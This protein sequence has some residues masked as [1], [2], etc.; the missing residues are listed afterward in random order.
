MSVLL[1]APGPELV[2]RFRVGQ[3]GWTNESFCE[4]LARLRE[5]LERRVFRRGV[6]IELRDENDDLRRVIR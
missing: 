3:G 4:V 6:V 2:V 5:K 1:D